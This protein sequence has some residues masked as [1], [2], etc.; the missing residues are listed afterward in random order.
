MK[1]TA[2]VKL[3]P[4]VEQAAR[5][6]QTLERANAACNAISDYAWEHET[7]G[8]YTLHKALYYTIRQQF[9][10][11]AQ[12]VVRCFSKVADAY[13]LDKKAKRQ[14]KP[15]SG[16]AYDDRI[17]NWRLPHK[18]VS[19]WTLGGRL[20]IPFA[21]G[22]RQW[23][24]LQTQQGESDLVCI[25]G[26]FYLFATCNV[27]EPTLVDVEGVLG[28]DLGMANIA[29]DSD[30]QA[31]SGSEIKN[32]RHR[33]RRLRKKL[34]SKGTLGSRRRLRKLAGKEKRFASHT[35]HTISKQLV[36]KAQGT[37]RAIAL[38]DLSGMRDRVTVRK[39]QR[40]QL[41]SWSFYQLRQYIEYKAKR[42]GLPVI[43]VD[44][45]N[46]SRTCPECGHCDKHNR[47]NQSTFSCVV[48]GYAAHADYVASV[49]I[50]RRA[51]VNPPYCSDAPLAPVQGF[52]A[53]PEQS[54][55][56]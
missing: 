39:P 11:A 30:G 38:E 43:L 9:D 45:R 42:V 55:L 26:K 20:S 46:T 18:T 28:V 56:V 41:H 6:K 25:G 16:V 29:L 27:D 36:Q 19:I 54:S 48:C 4:N 47:P 15:H 40:S 31:Y 23:E 12:V 1:L 44:P 34:Q 5:L 8:Q 24:L 51:V 17:L 33:H 32:V 3:L 50:S 10:L 52:G 2:K 21:C 35:N 49:N 7:F 14:F 37:G 22:E 13:K 53:A